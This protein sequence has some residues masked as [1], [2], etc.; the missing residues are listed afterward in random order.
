MDSQKFMRTRLYQLL[1]GYPS[2]VPQF[3]ATGDRG[4]R[5]MVHWPGR[6]TELQCNT[7]SK[8]V[9]CSAQYSTIYKHH[10]SQRHLQSVSDPY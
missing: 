10:L 1:K 6:S 7:K 9:K 5:Y 2:R 4:L 8:V 3:L